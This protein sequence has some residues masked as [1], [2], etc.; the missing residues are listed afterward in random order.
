MAIPSIKNRR[1][2]DDEGEPSNSSE[3]L[4]SVDVG[5]CKTN[6]P[7]VDAANMMRDLEALLGDCRKEAETAQKKQGHASPKRRY[8]ILVC[9]HK[10]SNDVRSNHPSTRGDRRHRS[11]HRRSH[12]GSR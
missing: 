6:G 9:N 12:R 11:P 10:C 3:T 7:D 1:L 2:R 4:H 8:V 5:E